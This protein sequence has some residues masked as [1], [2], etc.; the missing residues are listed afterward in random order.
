MIKYILDNRQYSEEYVA[1]YT[2]APFIVSKTFDFKDGLFSGFEK[3]PEGP[4]LGRYDK[5]Q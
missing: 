3:N 1:L 5:R 2:N 4:V